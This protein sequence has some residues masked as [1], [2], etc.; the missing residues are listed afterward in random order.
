MN[1]NSVE[2]ATME[3][4]VS[5]WVRLNA[6]WKPE[7]NYGLTSERIQERQK[8]QLHEF[9]RMIVGSR[10]KSVETETE[11]LLRLYRE[12]RL[13]VQF[14]GMGWIRNKFGEIQRHLAEV[15][16][17][18]AASV[19]T[20]RVPDTPVEIAHAKFIAPLYSSTITDRTVYFEIARKIREHVIPVCGSEKEAGKWSDIAR[21]WHNDGLEAQKHKETS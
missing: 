19:S 5:V 1:K 6:S 21:T 9:V 8:E 15:K 18:K 16:A 7:N 13:L 4:A 20:E 12:A 2:L 17:N 14:P 3:N 11:A 10:G